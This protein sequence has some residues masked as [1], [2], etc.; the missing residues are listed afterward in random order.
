[1]QVMTPELPRWVAAALP[2]LRACCYGRFC[3][4]RPMHPRSTGRAFVLNWRNRRPL[5]GFR[6]GGRNWPRR[7]DHLQ[8]SARVGGPVDSR[9]SS[10]H[11]AH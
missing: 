2:L 7:A 4:L 11:Q 10:L 3:S 8:A 6:V 9:G 1:M 5:M